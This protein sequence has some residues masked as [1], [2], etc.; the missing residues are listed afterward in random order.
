M[1]LIKLGKYTSTHGIKGEMKILTDY[2]IENFK[3]GTM[4][5]INDKSYQ[6]LSARPHKKHI[7]IKL[8]GLDSIDQ[9]ISLKGLDIYIDKENLVK[10]KINV[11]LLGFSVYN[12]KLYLGNIIEIRKGPKFPF[13]ITDK[14]NII[15][16]L[17]QF[18]IEVNYEE[19]RIETTYLLTD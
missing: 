9:I 3:I 18:I 14:D 8:E 13:L 2:Q 7:M 10:E 17:E 12:K 16:Y 19:K 6:L 5:T 1:E 15:P 4:I 11:D